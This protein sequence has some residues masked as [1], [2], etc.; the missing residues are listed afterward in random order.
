MMGIPAEN[1]A[2]KYGIPQQD[3]DDFALKSQR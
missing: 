1:V 2:Q 3:Q